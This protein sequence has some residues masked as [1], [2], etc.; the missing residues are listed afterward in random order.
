MIVVVRD[1][2][3]GLVSGYVSPPLTEEH[4]R[5]ARILLPPKALVASQ[6]GADRRR[7]AET[8]L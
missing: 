4:R 8:P 1:S 7:F 5:D 6:D 3:F 2:T